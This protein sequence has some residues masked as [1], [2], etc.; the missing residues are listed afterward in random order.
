MSRRELLRGGFAAIVSLQFQFLS[1]LASGAELPARVDYDGHPFVTAPAPTLRFERKSA[2]AP[3]GID[4]DFPEQTAHGVALLSRFP[5]FTLSDRRLHVD[6]PWYDDPAANLHFTRGIA[7]VGAIPRYRE[8]DDAP[9]NLRQ[10]SSSRKWSLMTD[11]M[12]WGHAI[13]LADLL[14][15]QN[16][17]DE[18]IAAL[19]AFGVKHYFTNDAAAFR[20][21][22]RHV[23]EQ[24]RWAT[25]AQGQFVRYPSIDIETT[26]GWEHQ[27]E[28]F[29]WLY[30]G[31][32][33]GA[34]EQGLQLVPMLYGQWQFSVGCFWE[35]MR[36]GGRGDPEYL[37]PEKDFLAGPDPTLAACQENH[38]ILSMDGYQQ[39][40]WGREP[41]FKRTATG[42]LQL[43][44]GEPVF[45]DASAT[46][47]YGWNLRLETGEAKQC[48]D[49]LYRSALRMYLQHHRRAGQYPADSALT[50]DFLSNCTI[51]AW[52]RYSNEGLQGI[53]QNDRPL[54]PWLLEW[55]IGLYLFTADDLTLWSSDMNFYPGALG[56]NYTNAW[57]YNAHGV[58]ESVVKAAHRYSA[59]DPLHAAGGTFQWCW[60]NLPVV[61]KNETPG[62]RYFEKPVVIG[63]LRPFAGHTYLEL[64][65]AWPALDQTS[66]TLKIW[67][68][69]DGH[70]SRAYT[71]Q[72]P[73]GRMYF[74]DAWQLPDEFRHLEGQH[75]WLRTTDLLGVQRTWRGDWRKPAD[76]SVPTP[77][78]FR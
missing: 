52:S 16:P 31:L 45:N 24:E 15:K 43:A 75:V 63:K 9:T 46:T 10:V 53:E 69:Q 27:R 23:F 65:A 67:L 18:R 49:N 33:E 19:R 73:H 11:P 17:A 8:K 37:L 2:P 28:C 44:N 71:L 57:R 13:R 55:L 61:N 59:L 7:S 77:A 22:G 60:F 74:Y 76:N 68:D 47:A 64:F 58:L 72:L 78:D 54:P 50:K 21:L 62:D 48:L 36:Q 56:G 34:R 12:W 70:R 6:G 1:A 29:G 4:Y 32:A 38:G 26:G 3:T 40:I 66:K 25:D 41:F 35:S 5:A 42:A 51:G 20:A 30:Q 39:A 14:E